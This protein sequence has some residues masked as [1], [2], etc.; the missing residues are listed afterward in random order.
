[1]IQPWASFLRRSLACR[2]YRSSVPGG[3]RWLGLLGSARGWLQE[4]RAVVVTSHPQT[5][6]GPPTGCADLI[7]GIASLDP[8]KGK[9]PGTVRI[10]AVRRSDGRRAWIAQVPGTQ[11]WSLQAKANP[12]DLTG[13]VEGMANEA[14]AGRSLVEAALREAGAAAGE[15]VMLVGH[16]QGGLVAAQLAADPA[17]R[18]SYHVTHVVT[19]GAPV[20]T[21]RIPD[22][23]SVL[24]LEH[25]ED[26]IS[27]LD[28]TPNPDRP[29]WVTVSR[30]TTAAGGAPSPSI[31]H[32][33]STYTSTAAAVDIA[34]DPGLARWRSGVEPF[35]D[36][37]GVTATGQEFTGRR[38]L[39]DASTDPG[40]SPPP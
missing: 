37:P 33:L 25:D 16:S 17:F 12:F 21:V 4:S 32:D 35:L 1:M 8:S 38:L 7:R 36:A 26:L 34:T 18:A 6:A 39:S 24:A 28:G 23:V 22:S 29:R 5:P 13:N 31:A 27:R 3:A 10:I 2:R 30:S 15:P 14:T 19:A 11:N 20:G 40:G 9:P